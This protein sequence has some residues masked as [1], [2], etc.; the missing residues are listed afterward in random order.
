MAGAVPEINGKVVF[1]RELNATNFTRDQIYTSL[2]DWSTGKF[3]GQKG[4]VIYKNQAEGKIAITAEEQFNVRIG[5]T[6]S[7]VNLLFLITISCSDNACSMTYSRVR[8]TN[9][10]FSKQATDIEPAENYIVDKYAINKTNTKIFKGPGDYRKSTIDIIDAVT[11]EAQKALYNGTTTAPAV[12][13]QQDNAAKQEIAAP[14]KQQIAEPATEMA[15]Q[16]SATAVPSTPAMKE[17][18][19]GEIPANII[20][21]VAR[22]GFYII[23]VGGKP[24]ARAIAGGGGLDITS[25]KAAAVFSVTDNID[26]IVYL[27]E[28]ADKYTLAYM[29]EGTSN[30]PALVIECKKMQQFNKM[31]VGEI[32]NT[33]IKE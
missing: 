27:L 5:I 20:Q 11:A 21:G 30:E 17:I 1:T 23:A 13:P 6:P 14:V 2:L 3:T 10:P 32:L 25:E 22:K 12:R 15:A 24:L 19:A 9:N 4:A 33:K 28:I 26:N 7:D 16:P 8:Y 18:S 29:G 31:F